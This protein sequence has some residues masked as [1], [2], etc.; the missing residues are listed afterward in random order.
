MLQ[1]RFLFERPIVRLVEGLAG[2]EEQVNDETDNRGQ[3]H[4]QDREEGRPPGA[5]ARANIPVGPDD[6]R[7]PQD[8]QQSA[9]NTQQEG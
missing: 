4:E 8:K 3:S 1:Q 7:Q 2:S 9:G 6:N 5:G